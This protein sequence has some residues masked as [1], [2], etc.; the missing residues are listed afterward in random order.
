MDGYLD[1][2]A[3]QELTS[4]DQTWA[5]CELN[6]RQQTAV[7]GCLPIPKEG[8]GYS[9]RD[10]R[11]IFVKNIKIRGNVFFANEA[12]VTAAK[13]R[14]FVRIVIVKD[15]RCNGVEM[16]A[17]DALGPRTGSDGNASL[18][19][20]ASVMALTNPNGWGRFRILKNKLI[21]CPQTPAFNDGTDGNIQGYI[22]PFSITVKVNCEVN[23]DAST[24][25]V[26]S[27]VDNAFHMLAA[28]STTTMA[29]VPQISYLA[30]TAFIG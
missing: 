16:N 3:V 6:P 5:G 18:L 30:R 23:F 15:T 10:G 7:Y 29:T 4:N 14:G 27:V 11:K 21:R 25:A 13:T 17:E 2:T 8:T 22:V 24:G 26:G 28:C 19:A 12:A 9:E 20:D 1:N